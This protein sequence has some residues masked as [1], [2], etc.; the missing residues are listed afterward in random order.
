MRGRKGAR[1]VFSRQLGLQ[2]CST[3]QR[4][5]IKLCY[6]EKYFYERS[7]EHSS[8]LFYLKSVKAGAR[9][10]QT[11]QL[12]FKKYFTVCQWGNLTHSANPVKKRKRWL[13]MFS[14]WS[15]L[16][17][18]LRNVGWGKLWFIRHWHLGLW[19]ET[20]YWQKIHLCSD[21]HPGM[22]DKKYMWWT[23]GFAFKWTS[24]NRLQ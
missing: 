6:T 13:D 1:L 2:N 10:R 19:N 16:I 21:Q 14:S 24:L 7:V 5:S 4:P 15:K 12:S 23:G 22:M 18:V 9:C 17:R 11:H 8:S 20:F 3:F